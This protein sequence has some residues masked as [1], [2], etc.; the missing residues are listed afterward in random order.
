MELSSGNVVLIAAYFTI[1]FAIGFWVKKRETVADYL[2]AE[3]KLGLLQTA[4]SIS[5]VM[6]GMILVAQATLGFEMG[7]GAAWYFVG[8]A[9]GMI[10]LGLFVGKVKKITAEKNFLTLA[11]YFMAKLDDKNRVL[12]AVIIF[13]ALFAL[14]VGQF[15]AAGSLFAPL[16]GIN[17]AMAVLLTMLGV[18]TYLLLGGFKAVVKTDVLQFAIM[19][20][21]FF[22]ILFFIDIGD[23]TPEQVNLTSIGGSYIIIFLLI[24]AFAILS[25]ADIWQRVFAARDAKTARN[26]S[27]LSAFFFLIFGAVLTIIGI[28]AKNNFPD[29][30]PE[31]ALYHGLFELVP[32]PLVGIAVIFVLAAIMS[33]IDTELFYLSSSIS[34]DFLARKHAASDST[35]AKN[36]RTYILVIALISA[37][38]AIVFSNILAVLFGIV[39][40]SL[41][42]SPTLAASFF[43]K[44]KKNAAFLS[45]LTG[46][47]SLVLLAVTGN[48]S[49]DNSIIPLPVAIVFLII[50]QIFF[51]RK[52]RAT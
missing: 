10:F 16:L 41:A 38:T 7:I 2:N 18:L 47:L 42:I 34:K 22:S 4:A 35:L 17:Y 20:V 13:I 48:F 19:A 43:W 26:A 24:G 1:V 45:M 27:F 51:E 46:L 5:A 36:I 40:L 49:S 29:I 23:Y 21:V 52:T 9:V 25:G 6:G 14:L 28:A 8:I 15:I 50:G 37:L 44:I 30:K 39:S 33:T 32:P 3:R 12:S 11:D 31:E